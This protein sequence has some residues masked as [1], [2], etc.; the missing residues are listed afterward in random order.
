LRLENVEVV[1]KAPRKPKHYE[2]LEYDSK[3]PVVAGKLWHSSATGVAMCGAKRHGKPAWDEDPDKWYHCPY[4]CS[5]FRCK[6]HAKNALPPVERILRNKHFPVHLEERAMHA[7]TDPQLTSL[8]GEIALQKSRLDEIA[9][10]LDK[11]PPQDIVIRADGEPE[12]YDRFGAI[13]KGLWKEHDEIQAELVRLCAAENRRDAD[14]QS[15]LNSR[16]AYLLVAAMHGAVEEI[17]NEVFKRIGGVADALKSEFPD[18]PEL[19]VSTAGLKQLIHT[20]FA[21]LMHIAHDKAPTL[22]GAAEFDESPR[23][24]QDLRDA[25]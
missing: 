24:L 16:E 9:L 18:A 10:L 5:P 1:A 17:V 2:C 22:P 20:R 6:N 21:A 15:N 14:L 4:P 13:R 25:S 7:L 12:T 11:I 3:H 8:R 23:I 19:V